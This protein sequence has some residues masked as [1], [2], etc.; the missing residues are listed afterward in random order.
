MTQRYAHRLGSGIRARA[1]IAGEHI[2]ATMQAK[3]SE[4]QNAEE[5][6]EQNPCESHRQT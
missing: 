1:K 4:V 2:M 6:P 3:A 5:T